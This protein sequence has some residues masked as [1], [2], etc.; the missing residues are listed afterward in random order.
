M[1]EILTP[2]CPQCDSP[3]CMV[4]GGDPPTQAFCGNDDCSTLCWNPTHSIDENL[5][6]T[7][8]VEIRQRS[9]EDERDGG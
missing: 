8:F 6:D 2:L 9:E 1:P 7:N 3:P 4:L 5:L